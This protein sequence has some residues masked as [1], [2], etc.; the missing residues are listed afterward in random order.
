M[1]AHFS[2]QIN[3]LNFDTIRSIC[4]YLFTGLQQV[5]VKVHKIFRIFIHHKLTSLQCTGSAVAECKLSS[6][7]CVFNCPTAY[8]ILVSCPGFKSLSSALQG[9]FLATGPPRKSQNINIIF[10]FIIVSYIYYLLIKNFKDQLNDTTLKCDCTHIYIAFKCSFNNF[11]F[12][13]LQF[14]KIYCNLPVNT[15]RFY[16]SIQIMALGVSNK[17]ARQFKYQIRKTQR[18]GKISYG[19]Q[20]GSR[21]RDKLG[22]WN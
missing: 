3:T 2:I 19:Y 4:I 20:R 17:L 6:Q 16:G 10:I 18:H 22:M 14:A 7:L 9:R 12:Y 21:R 8:G 13:S 5:L 1:L 15:R 11:Q